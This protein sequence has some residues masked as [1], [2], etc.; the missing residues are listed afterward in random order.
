[1]ED[2]ALMMLRKSQSGFHVRWFCETCMMHVNNFIDV[3]GV[4]CNIFLWALEYAQVYIVRTL[5]VFML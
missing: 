2:S 5:M 1:M 3:Y 4:A